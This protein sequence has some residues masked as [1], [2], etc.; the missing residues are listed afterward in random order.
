LPDEIFNKKA[1][2]CLKN[3][4]RLFKGQKNAKLCGIAIPLFKKTQLQ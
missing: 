2:Q 3:P 1:K 4:N